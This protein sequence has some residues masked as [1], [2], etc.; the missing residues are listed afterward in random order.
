MR[1]NIMD[2][3]YVVYDINDDYSRHA[4]VTSI[5][6]TN[7]DRLF[8]KLLGKDRKGKVGNT[9]LFKLNAKSP[10][11]NYRS[12][13]ILS[14]KTPDNTEIFDAL[15]KKMVKSEMILDGKDEKGVDLCRR[16]ARIRPSL[17]I[18]EYS[19]SHIVLLK[20]ESIEGINK[21]TFAEEQQIT[22]G[23]NSYKS[24]IMNSEEIIKVVDSSPNIAMYWSKRFLQLEPVRT[25]E[26]NSKILID[27]II[28]DKAYSSEFVANTDFKQ[29]KDKIINKIIETTHSANRVFVLQ[30]FIDELSQGSEINLD[31]FDKLFIESFD[32]SFDLIPD[33]IDKPFK[34][35]FRVNQ[36]TKIDIDNFWEAR[37]TDRIDYDPDANEIIIKVDENQRQDIASRFK[38][39]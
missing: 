17:L 31:S 13:F 34:A 10:L 37:K 33:V 28:N 1:D 5:Q 21:D 6:E 16:D 39:S 35:K 22:S 27:N 4:D 11:V 25:D 12:A 20:L 29:L 38:E 30:D 18:I 3:K 14:G 9:R 26:I 32:N 36:F 15:A 8:G 19:D 23:K 7:L 2:H 24:A